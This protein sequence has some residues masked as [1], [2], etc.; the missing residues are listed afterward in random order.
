[1]SAGPIF[2][3]TV[4]TN[5]LPILS[6]IIDDKT[7]GI[8]GGMV[9]KRYFEESSMSKAYDIDLEMGGTGLASEKPEGSELAIGNIF[10]GKQTTYYAR[11]FGL[12]F[13]VTDEAKEDSQYPEVLK[14]ARR[15]KR[16]MYK[17]VEYD[18][19]AVLSRGWNS[20]FVGGDGVALF[21]SSHTLPNGGTFSNN[22]ATPMTPSRQAVSVARAQAQHL[23]GHDGLIEGYT[24]KKVLFPSEQYFVWQGICESEYA[25]DPGIF[26][27]INV[28][29][30]MALEPVEVK[31]WTSTTTNSI[32]LTDAENGLKWKWRKR[33]FQK[34]WMDNDQGV[35][36]FGF[37]A[38][39]VRLW[40][41][42]RC[43][44][45]NQA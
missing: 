10:E 1:M 12:K 40:S 6:D 38:R 27:E 21:S 26:N 16:A 23:V 17:T 8:E 22:M 9:M 13:I 18:A 34:T 43:A 25:P 14:L 42:A 30:R 5:L 31:Y 41:D 4:A 7:D 11:T 36:K 32:F 39:W 33:P 24:L 20:S 2:T 35:E 29:K 45:G 19:A 15:G 3:S 44:I 28:V 37:Y